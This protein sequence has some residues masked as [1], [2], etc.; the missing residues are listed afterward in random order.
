MFLDSNEYVCLN[1]GVVI[2]YICFG[3]VGIVIKFLKWRGI[4]Y[5]KR[6]IKNMIMLG[7][8]TFILL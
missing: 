4:N 7:F 3:S 8:F 2:D 1:E 5:L 6:G